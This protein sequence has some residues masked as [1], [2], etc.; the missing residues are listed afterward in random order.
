MSRIYAGDSRLL[1]ELATERRIFVPYSAI[2]DLVKQA[3]VSAEDQNFFTHQRRRPDG[4]PAR[5]R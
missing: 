5:R 2:P 3:F 1:S 4:D